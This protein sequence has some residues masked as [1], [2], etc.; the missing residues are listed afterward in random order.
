[1]LE[2][3]CRTI[4]RNINVAEKLQAEETLG[5]LDAKI[6]AFFEELLFHSGD[7]NAED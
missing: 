5:A 4:Y 3:T 6:L 7:I 1:M 2:A